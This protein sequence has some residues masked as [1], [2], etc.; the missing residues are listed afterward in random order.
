MRLGLHRGRYIRSGKSKFIL[1]AVIILLIIISCSYIFLVRIQ[2]VFKVRASGY[3]ENMGIQTM[4]NAVNEVLQ[5]EN[6]TYNSFV[7]LHTDNSNKI[8]AIEGNTPSMNLFKTNITQNIQNSIQNSDGG[9]VY[10][11]IGSLLGNEIFNGV[12]CKVPVKIAPA[13]TTKIDFT[14]DFQSVGINQVKHSIYLNIEMNIT[15][16]SSSMQQ[17]KTVNTTVLVA[18]TIIVGEVPTYYS[19]NGMVA[20]IGNNSGIIK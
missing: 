9:Y 14:G 2:P 15:I 19:G 7:T 17:T 11:P 10:I 18:E 1:F 6:M 3:A 12:G 20:S 5:R 13:S 4:N 16:I 8:T